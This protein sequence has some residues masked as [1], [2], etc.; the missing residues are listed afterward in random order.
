[1]QL[2][3]V[4]FTLVSVESIYTSTGMNG[5]KRASVQYLLGSLIHFSRVSNV[6]YALLL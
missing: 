6:S 5:E 2:C 3:H 4:G 1:M